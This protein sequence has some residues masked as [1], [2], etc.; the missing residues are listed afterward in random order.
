MPS[1]TSRAMPFAVHC[2]K[3]ARK[4]HAHSVQYANNLPYC[5]TPP[6]Y[7]GSRSAPRGVS[8]GPVGLKGARGL[9]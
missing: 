3:L 4:L 8:L 7:G 5:T 2:Y 6:P 1:V 9:S